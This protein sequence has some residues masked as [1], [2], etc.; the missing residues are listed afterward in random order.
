MWRQARRDGSTIHSYK[1][2]HLIHILDVSIPTRLLARAVRTSRLPSSTYSAHPYRHPLRLPQLPGP[3]GNIR[4]DSNTGSR[5]SSST[6]DNTNSPSIMSQDPVDCLLDDIHSL[7]ELI[8]A[9]LMNCS[10]REIAIIFRYKN[11]EWYH[12]LSAQDVDE[13][14]NIARYHYWRGNP[15]PKL[16]RQFH[17]H[18]FGNQSSYIQNIRRDIAWNAQRA[19]LNRRR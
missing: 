13:I 9:K 8:V 16:S 17:G 19:G 4:S 18:G 5:G 3:S 12:A 15:Y 1:T 2:M 10:S 14:F 11:P 6:Q 7:E